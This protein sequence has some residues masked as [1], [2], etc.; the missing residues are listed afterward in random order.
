MRIQILVLT[1]FLVILFAIGCATN[2]S[3][4]ANSTGNSLASQPPPPPAQDAVNRVFDVTQENLRAAFDDGRALAQGS[5]TIR[6]GQKQSL[7]VSA[8]TQRGT[9]TLE[10]TVTFFSPLDQARLE[11][12]RLGR[13]APSRTPRPPP[14]ENSAVTTIFD[15]RNEVR[16]EVQLGQ[17][18]ERNAIIPTFSYA[19]LDKDG[20]RISPTSEPDALL[21]EGHN[22]LVPP[23]TLIFPVFNGAIPSLTSRMDSMVLIVKVDSQ[24]HRLQFQLR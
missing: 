20:N 7:N 8:P 4:N 15:H 10:L 23:P 24:E 3:G 5:P 21:D 1:F 6:V 2:Q 12:F 9:E 16:F 13:G 19:L 17:P 22:L 14:Q 18:R 11:G